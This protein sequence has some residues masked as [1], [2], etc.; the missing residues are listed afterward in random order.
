MSRLKELKD[1][2]EELQERRKQLLISVSAI[3]DQIADFRGDLD[4]LQPEDDEEE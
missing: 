2:I 3:D 4:L 1:K